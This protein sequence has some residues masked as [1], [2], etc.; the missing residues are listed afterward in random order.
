V[1]DD[2]RP[3]ESYDVAILGGGLA[4]LTLGLQ[5]KQERPETSIF[6]ADKAAGPARE[7]AHKVG[8]STQ[9]ISCHYFG[10]V[11]GL[12]EHL[13]NEQIHKCGLR[14]WFPAGD[15][16]DLA[17]RVERGP[18]KH[19]PVPSY[20]LDR[21]RFENFLTDKCIEAGVDHFRGRFIQDVEIGDPHEV[22]STTREGDTVTLKAHWVVDASGRAFTLKKK[23]DLLEGTNHECN[24]CWFRLA[25]GLDI[26]D[27][28]DP[29][30]EEF[31]GRMEERGLRMLS[32]NHIC[33]EGYWVWLIPLATGYISIGI[34]ADPRFHPWEQINTL[35]GALEWIKEH[36]P[37][38]ADSLEGRLDQIEDFLKVEH[39]SH[40]TKKS[41]DGSQRWALVGE[42][43]P[44]LDPFYSPGSDYIAMANEFTQDL[45]RRE[46]DGEDITERAETHNDLYL[47]FFRVHLAF[48]DGQYEFWHNPLV[49]NVKIGGN[50]IYYW[51]VLGL[52]YFHRKFTDLDFM[53]AVRPDI[54]RIWDITLKLE[55]MY[56]E[57][58]P[59]EDREWTRAMVPTQAFPAMFERHVDMVGGFDDETLKQKVAST[60]E[61]MEA[62]AVLAFNRAASALPDGAPD[63]NQKINPYA[64]SLDP[65]RW[66]EDG[67]FNGEGM[68][69]AEARQTP[70][71]GMEN[72]FMEA[73]ATPA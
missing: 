56:R 39:F 1:S 63:E 49:M 14:F 17:Q 11:L 34:V 38:L 28:A 73:I 68:S 30:D 27:W 23:L 52:L 26:E 62:Y 24:S 36:E 47:N 64:V 60:R 43:G 4:G 46:L 5:L 42:A 31:F 35:E 19:P 66:E 57:W 67:L 25:G 45:V 58:N 65:D 71:Q 37:Q 69:V 32:T 29:S 72:L 33:G 18:H 7:A 53:A 54:E 21:G 13:E 51:G 8:E 12:R 16:S 20:Q 41:M 40:G 44:F 55:A 6:I 22:T 2:R 10:E 48:Y 9:E 61:L 70:A 50:N 15:N 59:L 3:A